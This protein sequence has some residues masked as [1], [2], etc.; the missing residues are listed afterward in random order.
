MKRKITVCLAILACAGAGALSL[1]GAGEPDS[2]ARAQLRDAYLVLVAAE[3]LVA[4]GQFTNSLTRYTNALARYEVIQRDYP[5]W[6]DDMIAYRIADCKNQALVIQQKLALPTAGTGTAAVA[7]SVPPEIRLRKMLE[8]LDRA[9]KLLAVPVIGDSAAPAGAAAVN[10]AEPSAK[11]A[12]LEAKIELLQRNYDEQVRITRALLSEKEALEKKLAKL[13]KKYPQ[14]M[15]GMTDLTSP[16]A[17]KL[18]SE[19]IRKEA[20]RLLQG[21]NLAE[22]VALLREAHNLFPEDL[23]IQL[24]LGTAHCHAAQYEEALTLLADMKETKANQDEIHLIRGTAYMGAGQLGQARIEMEAVLKTKP[25]SSAA[26]YNLAQILMRLAPPDVDDAERY[27]RKS[28][29]NGGTR[30]NELE[31]DLREALIMERLPA[32]PKQRGH[33]RVAAPK[34]N[35]MPGTTLDGAPVMQTPK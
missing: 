5:G 29:A 20:R 9:R 27:Y 26:C 3:W 10:P 32:K 31:A 1:Q 16:D 17:S 15:A 7:E 8:E 33:D 25:D 13:A 12:E 28:I 30:D 2:R 18:S 34:V 23:A 14:L 24:L 22:T 11:L 35:A 6:Q 4:S 19:L 21:G